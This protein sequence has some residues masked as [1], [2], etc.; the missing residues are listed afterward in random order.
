M[1]LCKQEVAMKIFLTAATVAS[2]LVLALTVP[3]LAGWGIWQTNQGHCAL[4]EE[5]K[6]KGAEYVTQVESTHATY[7]DALLRLQVLLKAQ[8]CKPKPAN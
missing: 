3:T 1:H 6:K 8:S 7:K 2:A 4:F 5:G